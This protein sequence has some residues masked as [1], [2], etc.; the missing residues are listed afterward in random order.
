LPHLQRLYEEYQAKGLVI[1]GFNCADDH[2]IALQLMH[3]H[4]VTFPNVLD[5]S[6]AAKVVFWEGYRASGVPLQCFIDRDGKVVDAWYDWDEVGA[7][8]V[9]EALGVT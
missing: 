4:S 8:R 3:E 1:L 5:D 7:R 6:A 2:A 9:L